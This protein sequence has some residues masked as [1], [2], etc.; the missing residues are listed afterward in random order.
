MAEADIKY[1]KCAVKDIE[2][3]DADLRHLGK[4]STPDI[5]GFYGELLAWQELKI[6]FERKGYK[7]GVG[8]GQTR[9]D[10]KMEKNN[11]SLNIEVKTSRFKKEWFGEGYGFAVNIKKCKIHKPDFFVHPKK[12]KVYGDFCYFDY[13]IT[14]S[15][16]EDLK[17]KEFHI[18]SRSFFKAN[19]KNL[20]NRNKRFS[21]ATHRLIFIKNDNKSNEI[22]EFDR[23]LSRDKNNYKKW[24]IIK[25]NT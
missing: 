7:I 15:L 11:K 19:E 5:I 10:I 12:G 17:K 9:A 6:R 13:L 22:T 21:S 8:H 23:R 16:S 1:I 18:F 20:R 24:D 2:K 14:V 3:L 25:K 4:R